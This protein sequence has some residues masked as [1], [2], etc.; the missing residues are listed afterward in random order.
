MLLPYSHAW[1]CRQRLLIAGGVLAGLVSFAALVYS[2]E[3]YY[4]GPDDSV[5]VGTW[6]VKCECLGDNEWDYRFKSDH[7]YAR[8]DWAG[9]G[10]EYYPEGKWFAGG[11]FIYL[12]RRCDAVH[13]SYDDPAGP[14]GDLEVWH[15]DSMTSNAVRLRHEGERETWKRVE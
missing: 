12:I 11:D 14:Y 8:G 6:R 1:T 13:A 2:Y 7:S 10:K 3:R 4:R 9:Y 15:I 5:F